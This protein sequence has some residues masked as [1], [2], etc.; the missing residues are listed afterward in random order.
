MN[1]N[2]ILMVFVN[3]F[4]KICRTRRDV[5]AAVLVGDVQESASVVV[6]IVNESNNLFDAGGGADHVALFEL[7]EGDVSAVR[8]GDKAVAGEARGCRAAAIVD[9]FHGGLA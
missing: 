6:G 8:F 4:S 2:A 5:E 1:F 3:F 7:V 9:V